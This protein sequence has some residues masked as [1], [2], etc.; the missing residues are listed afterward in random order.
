M[1]AINKKL[2]DRNTDFSLNYKCQKREMCN[3]IKG[4]AVGFRSIFCRLPVK[5]T[6]KYQSYD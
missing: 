3:G 2:S 6:K 1:N 4:M 5:C